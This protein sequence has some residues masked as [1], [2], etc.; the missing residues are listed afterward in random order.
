M[1]LAGDGHVRDGARLRGWWLLCVEPIEMKV[2]GALWTT[3]G[4]LVSVEHGLAR[5]FLVQN[6][7]R[8]S[9]GRRGHGV[10]G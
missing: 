10:R 7:A 2:N 1:S 4:A 9:Y 5:H 3:R 6:A 8:I